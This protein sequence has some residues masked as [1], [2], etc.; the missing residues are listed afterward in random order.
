MRYDCFLAINIP[1]KIYSFFCWQ[2]DV[3][4]SSALLQM[5][6]ILEFRFSLPK[7]QIFAVTREILATHVLSLVSSQNAWARP[8][9]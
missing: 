8:V 6:N 2:N 1:F 9:A 5:A 3:C 4:E 7:A